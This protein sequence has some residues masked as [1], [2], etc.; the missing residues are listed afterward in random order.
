MT[1]VL[2][3]HDNGLLIWWEYY[4]NEKDFTSYALDVEALRHCNL[5]R[6]RG[7]LLIALAVLMHYIVPL[8]CNHR[9]I[10]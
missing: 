4:K 7:N 3:K 8:Y 5:G 2:G 1:G 9:S 10:F 6:I